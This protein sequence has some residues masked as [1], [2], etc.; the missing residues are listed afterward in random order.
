MDNISTYCKQLIQSI[1]IYSPEFTNKDTNHLPMALLA[2]S[3][4]GASDEQLDKFYDYYF[5]K[6]LSTNP[7]GFATRSFGLSAPRYVK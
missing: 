4:L 5:P 3:R 6:F 2:L 1:Q 7:S